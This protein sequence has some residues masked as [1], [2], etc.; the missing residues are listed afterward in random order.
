MNLNG[1]LGAICRTV[2]MLQSLTL[3]IDTIV[4]SA[5]EKSLRSTFETLVLAG[6]QKLGYH[7]E[8][9]EMVAARSHLMHYYPEKGYLLWMDYMGSRKKAMSGIGASVSPARSF[10]GNYIIQVQ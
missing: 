3:S 9:C 6:R 1:L 4:S 10:H 2:S 7:L 8:H 5:F